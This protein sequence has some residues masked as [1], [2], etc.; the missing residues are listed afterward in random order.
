MS[1]S[2]APTTIERFVATH[3][4]QTSVDPRA[5]YEMPLSGTPRRVS[6]PATSAGRAY[7]QW[8]FMFSYAAAIFVSG[9]TVGYAV[10]D[11]R[12]LTTVHALNAAARDPSRLR[13]EYDL[14]QGDFTGAGDL[15]R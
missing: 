14:R 7:T 4:P 1:T 15:Q 2:S 9:V 6:V 5:N 11:H 3:L 12:E 10:R 13:I 8:L